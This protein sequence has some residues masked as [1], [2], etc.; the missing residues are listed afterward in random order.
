MFNEIVILYNSLD[1]VI[2]LASF[3]E[4]DHIKM[5]FK[6]D[7]AEAKGAAP[8]VKAVFV[9]I[10]E[11]L[12]TK[13]MTYKRSLSFQGVEEHYHGTKLVCDITSN[14]DL[15]SS[16]SCNTCKIVDSGF[17]T[18]R[19]GTNISRFQRFGRGFYLAPNSSKCHD[20]TEGAFNLRALIV[21]DVCPGRKYPMTTNDTSRDGPPVG[22]DSIHGKTGGNLNYEEIVLPK[23]EAILPKYIVL[24]QKDGTHK[25]IE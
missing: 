25:L 4:F 23:P 20:Y 17:S 3:A 18:S 15:C 2:R 22:Y 12:K 6:Q 7:W 21:C 13:W 11:V 10:N 1:D 9:I 19:I 5:K 24:Y 16:Y 8:E 14:K